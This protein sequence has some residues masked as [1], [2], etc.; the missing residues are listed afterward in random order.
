LAQQ[1]R[2]VL[3]AKPRRRGVEVAAQQASDAHRRTAGN[4][5]AAVGCVVGVTT[6]A[7]HRLP[8][9]GASERLGTAGVAE[10]GDCRA[11]V[12]D[13]PAPC[14]VPAIASSFL[15]SS[16]LQWPSCASRSDATWC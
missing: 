14:R 3:G 9:A 5:R 8:D 7:A 2:A 4:A 12:G 11:A 15:H 10:L 1:R 6:R 16:S 13:L